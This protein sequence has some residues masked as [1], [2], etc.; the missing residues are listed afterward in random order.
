MRAAMYRAAARRAETF[1]AVLK[2]P[3]QEYKDIDEFLLADPEYALSMIRS[4]I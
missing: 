4:W 1:H 2:R 3:P